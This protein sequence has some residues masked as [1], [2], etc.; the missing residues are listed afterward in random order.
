MVLKPVSIGA[1][2]VEG[3]P[4]LA[5]HRNAAETQN[6]HA[7]VGLTIGKVGGWRC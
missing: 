2:E 3:V 7:A 5:V 1:T 4:L 6:Q